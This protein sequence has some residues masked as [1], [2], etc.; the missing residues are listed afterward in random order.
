MRNTIV[1]LHPLLLPK[2]RLPILEKHLPYRGF[3]TNS[4][5]NESVEILL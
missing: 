3:E 1:V 2:G 5:A 4:L